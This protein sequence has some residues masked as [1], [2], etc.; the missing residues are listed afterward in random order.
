MGDIVSG[1]LYSEPDFELQFSGKVAYAEDYL[2]SDPG[3]GIARP[4][5]VGTIY[6]D[7]G[8][9][10]FLFRMYVYHFPGLLF[11]V[12]MLPNYHVKLCFPR[13]S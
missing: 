12:S 4:A 2:T 13:R 5:C 11:E 8:S 6:P 1:G 9:L 3:D 7:D 10:P